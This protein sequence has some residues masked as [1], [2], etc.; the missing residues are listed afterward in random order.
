M[1]MIDFETAQR[2][3][4]ERLVKM[5]RD[6]NNFGS[7]LPDHKDKPYL[8]LV[9][10]KTTEYEFGW[11]FAYNTREYIETN[12]ISHALAGNAPLIVDKDDGQ[13]YVTGT[14]PPFEQYIEQYRKGIKRRA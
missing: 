7:A 14:A 13:I 11:V 12:N 3:I 4:A 1:N 8:H 5:E 10:T 9:V 6:M 2:I